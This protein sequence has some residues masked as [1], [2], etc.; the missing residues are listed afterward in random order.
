MTNAETLR[1]AIA[2]SGLSRRGFA[3]LLA[4]DERTMRRWVN[5]AIDVPGPVRVIAAAIIR[6]PALIAELTPPQ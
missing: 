1:R 6:N 2:A 5:E 4:V 3:G